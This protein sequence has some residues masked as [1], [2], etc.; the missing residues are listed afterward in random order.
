M[1]PE[2]EV[3][4]NLRRILVILTRYPE[5]YNAQLVPR[6]AV[7]V[8]GRY[9]ASLVYTL[10]QACH[11]G[12][13]KHLVVSG[14][15]GKDSGPLK[16]WGIPEAHYLVG[17][18]SVLNQYALEH[19]KIG[20]DLTAKNGFENARQMARMLRGFE[21]GAF[22]DSQLTVVAHS[23]QMVR[24]GETLNR[25]LGDAGI[26]FVSVRWMPSVYKPS[27]ERLQ[28]QWEICFELIKLAE[29][30]EAG[31]NVPKILPALLGWARD[32]LD[33]VA[34]ELEAQKMPLSTAGLRS[35]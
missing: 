13:P 35:F 16:E 33:R 30:D 1:N 8:F 2:A 4:A 6:G 22:N 24:L 17:A 5:A 34:A 21:Y 23:T 25:V 19:T 32:H 12:Q 15:A 29:M 7:A 10:A 9:C 28:D 14:N 27:L 20:I 18:A 31:W 26:T 11:Q 3:Q